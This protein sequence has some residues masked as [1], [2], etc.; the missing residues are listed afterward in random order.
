MRERFRDYCQRSRTPLASLLFILPLLASYE[1]GIRLINHPVAQSGGGLWLRQFLQ[2]QFH[3][4]AWSMPLLPVT[5]LLLLHL[6]CYRK[7]EAANAAG[8][9]NT[10]R[11]NGTSSPTGTTIPATPVTSTVSTATTQT[12]PNP[13]SATESSQR[14]VNWLTFLPNMLVES[15]LWAVMLCGLLL[16]EQRIFEMIWQT[17]PLFQTSPIESLRLGVAALISH[18]GAGIYE[19]Y[20]FRLLLVGGLAVMLRQNLREGVA[21]GVAILI[22]AVI[23]VVAHYLGRY[24]EAFLW[25]D[26]VCQLA[27]SF[28]FTAA[29]LLGVI[30]WKRGFGVAVGSHICYNVLIQIPLP[31]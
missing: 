12:V 19:E 15:I 7:A 25:R 6:W 1:L 4:P 29:I 16:A 3:M 8:M 9:A 24:G 30:F 26:A 20:L 18:L 23:F 11:A 5:T 14:R 2:S 10:E 27:M 22:G 13:T 17:G 31:F 28:R 21:F